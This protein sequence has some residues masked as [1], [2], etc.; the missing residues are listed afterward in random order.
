MVNVLRLFRR[1]KRGDVSK[2]AGASRSAD[3]ETAEKDDLRDE[4][5]MEED[6]R[7]AQM[8]LMYSGGLD[9]FGG[10]DMLP[11]MVLFPPTGER[12]D[13][14]ARVEEQEA[15]SETPEES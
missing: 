1:K 2:E 4:R 5:Q 10:Y 8:M 3:A 13:V 11:P 15:N 12:P 7:W 14:E 9:E 6:L